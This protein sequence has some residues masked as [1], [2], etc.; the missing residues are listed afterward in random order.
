VNKKTRSL[1]G[2]NMFLKK[3]IKIVKKHG[4]KQQTCKVTGFSGGFG[5]NFYKDG[6]VLSVSIVQEGH[7]TYPD[8][9]E[10]IEIFGE[11]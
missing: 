11:I 10:L 1:E 3:I 9:D 2:I 7:M 5:T 8:E 6:Q 4:W